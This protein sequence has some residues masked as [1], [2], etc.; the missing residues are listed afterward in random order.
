MVQ[1]LNCTAKS[2]ISDD[3]IE[4]NFNYLCD[5]NNGDYCSGILANGT[6]GKYGAYSMC[7]SQE[8]ISWA[9]NAFFMDQTKNNAKNTDPCNFKG[10]AQKQ[11]SKASGSCKDV[12]SQ[13]GDSGTGVI[14]GA[15]TASGVSS[16]GGSSSSSKAAASGL[17]VPGFNAGMFAFAAYITVAALVGA[18]MILL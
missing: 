8:R 13:A 2:D 15:P 9:F 10:A 7:S 11:T 14:T 18:G 16:G 4:T 6:T 1:S 5:P 17:A 3:A 12:V